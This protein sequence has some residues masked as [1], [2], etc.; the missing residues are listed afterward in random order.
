[1]KHLYQK[2]KT[3]KL[4]FDL[5]R[6]LVKRKLKKHY[7]TSDFFDNIN[8]ETSSKC[9]RKCSYCPNAQY[10][11]GNLFMEDKTFYKIIDEL[12]ELVYIGK[13]CFAFFN[14][15]FLDKRTPMFIA[16][17]KDKLPKC[18]IGIFTNGDYGIPETKADRVIISNHNDIN[19]KNTPLNNRCGLITPL[20][21]DYYP[22][23]KYE[24]FQ[25]VI[26]FEGKFI[27]CCNDYFGVSS[28]GNV[29]NEKIIDIWNK[30]KYIKLRKDIDKNIFNLE[31][32][33]RC[34]GVI[35]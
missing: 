2:Q 22:R 18:E 29:N 10:D 1:M 35:K 23:C 21:P 34:I 15:P 3:R 17:A 27:I 12:K 19:Y 26:N 30:P 5:K 20:N 13:I 24:D 6:A 33:K 11:R 31:I 25:V 14:E 4:K 28:M 8:L 32:C 9:N 16:Y 7:G